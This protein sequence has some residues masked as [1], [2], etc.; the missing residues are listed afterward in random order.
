MLIVVDAKKLHDKIK[1]KH[2]SVLQFCKHEGHCYLTILNIVYERRWPQEETLFKI[3]VSLNCDCR[4]LIPIEHQFSKEWYE[5]Y[6]SIRCKSLSRKRAFEKAKND[7]S[8]FEKLIRVQEQYEQRVEKQLLEIVKRILRRSMLPTNTLEEIEKNLG[9][10]ISQFR[11]HIEE[12]F[13]EC[14]NWENYG[15][16]AINWQIDHIKQ[17]SLFNLFEIEQR[18]ASCHYTNL[19]PLWRHE[20]QS[21][22]KPRRKGTFDLQT[23]Y[24]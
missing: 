8:S 15:K 3:C 19:R 6:A 2:S 5:G 11:R 16:G 24:V 22:E 17:F 14:M 12:S 4:E 9:C 20:N 1:E 7:F 23:P 10:S 18:K 21:R 13:D